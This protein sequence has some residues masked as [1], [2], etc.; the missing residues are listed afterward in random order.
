MNVALIADPND[1][2]NVLLVEQWRPIWSTIVRLAEDAQS[3]GELDP[4]I[5]ADTLM[6][7]I[8]A[9]LL[10]KT[11]MKRAPVDKH[12]VSSMIDIMT[13]MRFS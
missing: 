2:T 11:I 9:P 1:E 8:V 7:M 4:D 10:I 6:W 12:M 13:R 3:R 5:D